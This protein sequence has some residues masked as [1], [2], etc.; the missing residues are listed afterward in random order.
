MITIFNRKELLITLDLNR[1]AN[2]RDILAANDIDYAVKVVSRY[3]GSNRSRSGTFGINSNYLY[4]YKIY[5]H[6]KD[7]EHALLIIR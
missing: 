5:V 3:T 1:Q 4:E 7:Y 6:K 2:I